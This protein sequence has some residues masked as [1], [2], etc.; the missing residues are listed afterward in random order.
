MAIVHATDKLLSFTP[1]KRFGKPCNL[2]L[3]M[4]AQSNYGAEPLFLPASLL[5]DVS[6]GSDR[7][8]EIIELSGIFQTRHNKGNQ[9]TARTRYVVPVNPRSIS[10]QA[11][12][13]KFSDAVSAWQGLSSDER[14][15]YNKR[16][17]GKTMSGYNLFLKHYLNSH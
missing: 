4:F 3:S 14:V 11:N 12:R 9:L 8:A 15:W 2:G 1:K 7:Y 17:F 5:G 16:A 6:F 13:S 10:Q